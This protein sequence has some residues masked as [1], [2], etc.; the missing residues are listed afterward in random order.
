[1]RQVVVMVRMAP[2]MRTAA[3][4][5]ARDAG[6]SVSEWVRVLVARKLKMRHVTPKPTGRPRK[7]AP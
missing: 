3:A 4:K 5:A 6:V 7:V 2:E 1:M